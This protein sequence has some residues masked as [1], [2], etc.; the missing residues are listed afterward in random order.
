MTEHKKEPFNDVTDH[1]N[2]IEG[3]ASHPSNAKLKNLP[4]PLKLIGYF[5]IAFTAL[6]F[7]L[8]ILLNL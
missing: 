3:N 7:L 1:F 8:M 2:R 4:L 6:A 5:M